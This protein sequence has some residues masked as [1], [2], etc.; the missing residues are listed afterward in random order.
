MCFFSLGSLKEG[1]SVTDGA[2]GRNNG[3]LDLC[4]GNSRLRINRPID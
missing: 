4:Y 1:E 3:R 2:D